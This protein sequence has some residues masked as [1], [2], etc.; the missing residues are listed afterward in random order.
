MPG[1]SVMNTY[2]DRLSVNAPEMLFVIGVLV[3]LTFIAVKSI[4]MIKE[5]RI[6]KIDKDSEIE[7]QR[8]E[9]EKLREER[10]AE[11]RRIQEQLD[12]ERIEISVRQVKLGETQARNTEA[13]ITQLAA[14]QA[15]LD[16]SK[17]RSRSMGE[18]V[19]DTN[20]KVSEIHTIVLNTRK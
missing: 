8:L 5:L 1:D 18:T 11:E 16:E 7:L 13:Q 6:R 3:L 15:S 4:P 17:V 14:L 19:E 12:R 2:I 10:K 20:T 9:L